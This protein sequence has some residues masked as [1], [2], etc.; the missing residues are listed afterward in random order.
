VQFAVMD[1]TQR[2]GHDPGARMV[3]IILHHTVTIH[4]VFE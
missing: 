4:M 1:R 3:A 2:A